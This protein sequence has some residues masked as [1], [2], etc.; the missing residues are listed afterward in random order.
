M[1]LLS[2]LLGTDLDLIQSNLPYPDTSGPVTVRILELSVTEN[3]ILH[4][5]AHAQIINLRM[6]ST[7]I[8]S[9]CV[10]Q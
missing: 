7:Y 10:L 5:L 2:M 3:C 6:Q 4:M 9:T 1:F 8:D